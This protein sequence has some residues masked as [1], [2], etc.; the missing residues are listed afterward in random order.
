MSIRVLAFNT[1]TA[2]CS[3]ALMIDCNIYIYNVISLK[4]HAERILCM[5]D[6]LLSEVG[7]S[8]QS[9]D[10]LI[11]DRG[12]GSFTGVRIGISVAQ[13]LSLGTDLPL[14]E[15]SSLVVLAQ[16]AW[17]VFRARNIITTIAACA[18]KLYWASHCKTV[19][20]SWIYH[21]HEML[22]TDKFIQK[23]INSLQGDRWVLVG[24]GWNSYS[25]L[26]Y[27]NNTKNSIILRSMMFPEA[28]DMFSVGMYKWEKK[29]FI[30]T[31]KIKPIY[32]HDKLFVKKF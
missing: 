28:Q 14:I 8:L 27:V 16:G 18:G 26:K 30:A 4:F 20:N 12:P 21:N 19:D 11:F 17:R 31:D 23:L 22:I 32:L 25:H 29:L 1:T 3:V 15:V 2:L 7:I 24:T 5:I 10:C 9:L 6:R 13:G